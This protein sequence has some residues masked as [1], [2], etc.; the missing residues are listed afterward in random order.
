MNAVATAE[1]RPA[2][3][4]HKN[5]FINSFC[6]TY[7]DKE[8]V[9]V[10]FTTLQEFLVVLFSYPVVVLVEFVSTTFL[11]GCFAFVLLHTA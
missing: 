5:T 2:Y 11:V 3:H 7:E 6:R 1:N 10:L 9:Q 4:P 8:S